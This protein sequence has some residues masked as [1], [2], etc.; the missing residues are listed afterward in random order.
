MQISAADLGAGV[1]SGKAELG[2]FWPR[3]C[4]FEVKAQFGP[5][6]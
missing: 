4:G 6:R 2:A 3:Y 5:Q 1:I